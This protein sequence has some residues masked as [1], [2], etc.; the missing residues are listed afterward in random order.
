MKKM[1]ILFFIALISCDTSK[2]ITTGTYQKKRADFLYTL[3]LNNADST[4]ILTKKYFEVNSFCSGKWRQKDDS[5][6]LKCN[7]EKEISAVLLGGYMNEREFKIKIR[8]KNNLKLN[9][10]LLKKK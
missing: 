6:F 1:I 8:N 3:K 2:N 5:I 4:F 7:E 9:N 10:I